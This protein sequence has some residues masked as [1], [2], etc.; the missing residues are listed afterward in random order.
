MSAHGAL[1]AFMA[2]CEI[3]KLSGL[4]TGLSGKGPCCLPKGSTPAV[5]R[6]AG[7]LLLLPSRSREGC[8]DHFLGHEA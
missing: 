4:E 5:Q 1:K 6:I 3:G 7:T 2:K 8:K